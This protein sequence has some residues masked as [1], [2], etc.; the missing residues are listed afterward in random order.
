MIFDHVRNEC[1]A[2]TLSAESSMDAD[3]NQIILV[4]RVELFHNVLIDAE[5]FGSLQGF[6]ELWVFSTFASFS[7]FALLVFAGQLVEV[8]LSIG[9]AGFAW[10]SVSFAFFHEMHEGVE[11]LPTIFLGI[12]LSSAMFDE[13]SLGG[14]LL[15]RRL[16]SGVITSLLGSF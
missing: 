16:R 13:L 1:S 9:H 11:G 8:L 2:F 10:S 14:H 6:L 4:G 3:S 15:L 12:A 5:L 7:S